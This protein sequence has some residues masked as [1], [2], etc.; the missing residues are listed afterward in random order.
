MVKI[1]LEPKEWAM[2]KPIFAIVLICVWASNSGAQGTTGSFSGTVRDS[3]R[4]AVGGA[5][6]R[7]LN[8]ETGIARTVVADSAG[9][10]R[11]PSLAPG[12]YTVSAG[13]QGLQTVERGGVALDVA[14]DVVVNF[15]LSLTGGGSAIVTGSGES[16]QNSV[17]DSRSIRDLPLASRSYTALIPLELG[18]IAYPPGSGVS[19]EFS[20]GQ[21]FSADGGRGYT[22][23]FLLDGTDINDHANGTPGNASGRNPGIESVREF[24]VLTGAYK[25]EYGRASGAIVSAVTRSGSNQLHGSAYGF[26]LNSALSARN[27]FDFGDPQP[28]RSTQFGGTLGGPIRKDH[29]FLFGNYEGWRQGLGFT[30]IS[31]VPDANARQGLLGGGSGFLVNVGVAPAVRP[32][33]A[34]FP[35]PNARA[36][37]DGVA[38]FIDYPTLTNNG[39]YV[40]D[41]VDH[42]FGEK[43]NLFGRYAVD[44]DS[45]VSP[46]ATPIFQ[47]TL[48]ARRQYSTIQ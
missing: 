8:E 27:F 43:V 36:F 23:S 15:E 32:F 9:R 33:L 47:N 19:F 28:F 37:G 13:R 44:D 5:T 29:T 17:M 7:V 26:H 39:N 35:L 14:Q 12:T 45:Q 1:L 6:V 34:L 48:S 30:F 24:T 10:Y 42:Q 3:Q 16:T 41:R 46:T 11:A 21:R 25:A 20:A 38:E 40:L 22:N 2:S 18:V 31:F 4:G